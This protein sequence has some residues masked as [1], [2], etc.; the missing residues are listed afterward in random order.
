MWQRPIYYA[1]PCSRRQK[2]WILHKENGGGNGFGGEEEEE[3]MT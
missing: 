2:T 3:L 1:D